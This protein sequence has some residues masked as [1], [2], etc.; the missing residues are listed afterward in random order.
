MKKALDFQSIMMTLQNFWAERD[1]LIWQPYYSPGGCGDDEPGYVFYACWGRN[2]GK[3]LMW[4]LP[5]APM[6]VAMATIPTVCSN[7]TNSR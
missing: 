4:S 5:S 1:C 2:P 6:M 3:W 7:F